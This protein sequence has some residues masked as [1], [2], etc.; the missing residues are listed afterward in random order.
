MAEEVKKDKVP[1]DLIGFLDYWLVKK[2]PFQIPDNAKEWI[3]KFGP[4]ITVVLMVLTLP[5]LFAAI[6]ISAF[7]TPYTVLAGVTYSLW[8]WVGLVF[9]V[10]EFALELFA[11]PGLFARKMSGWTLLFYSQIVSFVYALIS[12]NVLGAILGA[13]IGLYILFQIREKY[14]K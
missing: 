7:L 13:I 2:A 11:L 9:I 12:G 3:V 5:L 8:Y 4:W 10:L 6:G 14:A 1:S